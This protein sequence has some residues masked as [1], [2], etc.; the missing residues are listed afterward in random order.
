MR[1]V[2]QSLEVSLTDGPTLPSPASP[3]VPPPLSPYDL[4]CISGRLDS[5]SRLV[6]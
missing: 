6:E 5:L 4:G 3:P 2:F 1:M